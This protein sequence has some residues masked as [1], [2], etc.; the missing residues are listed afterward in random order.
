MGVD[1]AAESAAIGISSQKSA[2]FFWRRNGFSSPY[3]FLVRLIAEIS[4]GNDQEDV[5]V[6]EFAADK[7]ND[8][9]DASDDAGNL[10]A[11]VRDDAIIYH[12][13][14]ILACQDLRIHFNRWVLASLLEGVSVRHSIRH[15]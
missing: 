12:H 4:D 8:E 6:D 11:A 14:P 7:K 2:V 3:L 1:G 13:I 9:I 5:E 10:Y 15:T